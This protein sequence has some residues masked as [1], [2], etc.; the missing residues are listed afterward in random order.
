MRIPRHYTF[1]TM[2]LF[3]LKANHLTDQEVE[4]QRCYRVTWSSKKMSGFQPQLTLSL[5]LFLKENFS[6]LSLTHYLQI[7]KLLTLTILALFWLH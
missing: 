3:S 6:F 7:T 5:F 1:K 2:C 4:A